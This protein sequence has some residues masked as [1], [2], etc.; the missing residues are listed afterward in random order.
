MKLSAIFPPGVAPAN[1]WRGLTNVIRRASTIRSAEQKLAWATISLA[2]EDVATLNLGRLARRKNSILPTDEA[3]FIASSAVDFLDRGGGI[4]AELLGLDPEWVT[5]QCRR[6][7]RSDERGFL[8]M[9]HAR[10]SAVKAMLNKGA[11]S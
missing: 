1:A 7:L 3:V 4:W 8:D 9:A 5:M 10:M 11:R 6:P 2:I